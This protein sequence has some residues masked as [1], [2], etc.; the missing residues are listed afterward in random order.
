MLNLFA[1]NVLKNT[2]TL[3]KVKKTNKKKDFKILYIKTKKQKT[4]LLLYEGNNLQ[5]FCT[6]SSTNS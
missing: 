2:Y 5:L 1:E 6:S 3:K 4:G